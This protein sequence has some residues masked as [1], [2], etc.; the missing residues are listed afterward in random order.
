[1]WSLSFVR[2]F[3]KEMHSATPVNILVGFSRSFFTAMCSCNFI[4]CF[5]HL[6]EIKGFVQLSVLLY[7]EVIM[8]S[9][10]S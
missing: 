4:I 1:M 10:K 3:S 5:N 8:L 6:I 7:G 9:F 2:A